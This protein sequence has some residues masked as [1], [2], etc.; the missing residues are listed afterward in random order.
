MNK[1]K[2]NKKKRVYA[3]LLILLVAVLVTSVFLLINRWEKGYGLFPTDADI[4]V[5]AV[6][7]VNGKDYIPDDDVQAI[8]VMGL[9]KF[10]D[11]LDDS[12]Y[13]N[14]Q[15]ADFLML[16]AVDN[17]TE[18]YSAIHLNRDTMAEINVLGVA[19]EKIDT[20]I[21]QLALAHTYG[22]GK[23]VSCRNTVDAVS[24]VLNDIKINHY[25]SVPMDAVPVVTDLVG[26]VRV[27]VEDDFS[28]I[29]E[30]LVMGESV[31]L[32]GNNVLNYVRSRQGLE[33]SS[34]IARMKRQQQYV[35]SL[36]DAFNEKISTDEN[37]IVNA[38]LEL[39]D[40]II[41]NYTVTQLENLMENLST[42]TFTE[43]YSFD[44]ESKVGERFM[45]FYPDQD[46]IDE[47][48]LDLFYKPA[49]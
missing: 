33:D 43:V 4:K 14:D 3:L 16:F 42:Y 26:G 32:D 24:G 20:T 47:L 25:V 8:L 6:I 38:S 37:F 13:T 31:L 9:D 45:E 44:G 39:S 11:A 27:D 41:S 7:K 48:V 12:G 17:K 40:Y 23:A 19:G 29:D 10:E 28:G 46:Q 2:N 35:Y 21:G 15:Q 49:D 18:T 30:T 36:F 22:N 1:T 34:N 5:N